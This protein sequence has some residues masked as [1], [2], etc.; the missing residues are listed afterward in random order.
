[1]E[2]K[3]EKQVAKDKLTEM[4]ES[5][6]KELEAIK[7]QEDAFLEEEKD[8]LRKEHN[9]QLKTKRIIDTMM[10][11]NSKANPGNLQICELL[12][13]YKGIDESVKKIFF[14]PDMG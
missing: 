8:V 3:A 13:N 6:R 4:N 10:V 11:T 2:K 12:S 14:C 5:K 1:M 7:R 9:D